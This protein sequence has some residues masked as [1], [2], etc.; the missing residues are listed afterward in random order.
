MRFGAFDRG[1]LRPAP[2]A[3]IAPAYI[4]RPA[5]CGVT[6]WILAPAQIFRATFDVAPSSNR[7]GTKLV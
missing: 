5:Y 6:G 1:R 7:L 3:R 4:P 2:D